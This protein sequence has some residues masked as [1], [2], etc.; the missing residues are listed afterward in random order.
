[1]S[2]CSW[3]FVKTWLVVQCLYSKIC[4]ANCV[5]WMCSFKGWL[6]SVLLFGWQTWGVLLVGCLEVL[7]RP[8][9]AGSLQPV[10]ILA[11][12]IFFGDAGKA[13]L[14]T[15]C[16]WKIAWRFLFFF[17]WGGGGTGIP[18]F[19]SHKNCSAL[20]AHLLWKISESNLYLRFIYKII[21][22]STDK[23]RALT[24]RRRGR[25]SKWAV[26]KGVKV[27]ASEGFSKRL[28]ARFTQMNPKKELYLFYEFL[29]ANKMHY[30]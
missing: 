27:C 10:G 1:M 30:C 25:H 20:F 8:G 29:R 24:V 19:F 22:R 26:L 13:T 5:G 3:F 12:L 2:R 15:W 16:C 6:S 14:A 9:S 28:Q 18:H 7:G 21:C 17:F 4:V 11:R 23:E